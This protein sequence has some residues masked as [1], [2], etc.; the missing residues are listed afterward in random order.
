PGPITRMRSLTGIANDYG[1]E[2]IFARQLQGLVT[3][4]DIV[5]GIST[6]GD[7]P[8]VLRGIEEAK[9]RGAITIAFTGQHGKLK[10]IADYTFCVPSS[11]YKKHTLWLDTLSATWSKKPPFDL[12]ERQTWEAGNGSH[13]NG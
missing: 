10:K 4:G 7:S 3:D 13:R 9:G 6:S 12:K 8:N 2:S 5:I 11:E 1:Y